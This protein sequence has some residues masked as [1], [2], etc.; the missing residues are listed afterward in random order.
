MHH[1]GTG[2]FSMVL[3]HS[4]HFWFLAWLQA[5]HAKFVYS[6]FSNVH[7]FPICPLIRYAFSQDILGFGDGFLL[8]L[9]WCNCWTML[10]KITGPFVLFVMHF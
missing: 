6:C 3:V 1:E 7:V 4:L 2:A 8:F 10:S 9:Y 5:I